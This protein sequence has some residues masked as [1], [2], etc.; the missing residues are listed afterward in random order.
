MI[1]IEKI[2]HTRKGLKEEA[3]NETL[4][5]PRGEAKGN[6]EV[7]GKQNSPFSVEPVIKWFVIPLN[8]KMEKKNFKRL[9]CLAP[10]GTTSFCSFKV[11]DLITCESKVE[12]VV[13][14]GS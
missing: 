4:N 12:V 7:E 2:I 9:I 6:I 14:I 10:A 5:V 3:L 1:R 8:S 13:S 11:C